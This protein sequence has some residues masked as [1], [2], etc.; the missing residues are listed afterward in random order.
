[1]QIFGELPFRSE[2]RIEFEQHHPDASAAMAKIKLHD[3]GDPWLWT[4]LSKRK[5][6]ESF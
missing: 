3:N 4:T 1:M 6:F 2:R 5:R